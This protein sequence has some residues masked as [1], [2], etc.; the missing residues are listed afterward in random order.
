MVVT[1]GTISAV[2]VVLGSIW[3]YINVYTFSPVYR[4]AFFK[5]IGRATDPRVFDSETELPDSELPSI[6]VLLP[7]YDE[8]ETV[9][10]AIGALRDAEYPTEK[11]GVHVV[12]EAADR[13]T[14][15]ELA[16]LGAHYTFQTI[17]V[18]PSYPGDKNKPRA[19]NYGFEHTD[20]DI[21]GVVDAEDIVDPRL[22]RQVVNALVDND[23]D[24]VQGPLDLRNED[25]GLLNVLFRGEYGFWYGSIIPSY[26]RV[27]YPVPLGGTTNFI[28]RETLETVAERR[29][30]RFGPLWTPEQQAELTDAGLSGT[31]PW[32]PRNVTE[33]FELGLFLWELGRSMAMVTATTH[34]ES[35]VGLNA[36]VRQRTR[37]QRGKLYTLIRRL[38]EPPKGLKAKVHIY[39]QSAV[40]HLGPINIV[41]FALVAV[42]ATLIGLLASL[43]ATIILSIGL[44]LAVQM[45]AIQA[46]GYWNVTDK[47]GVKRVFRTGVNFFAVPLYWTLVWGSDVRAFLQLFFSTVGWEKTTHVGRHIETADPTTVETMLDASGLRL[48]LTEHVD[49]W[50]WAARNDD[51]EI[52][53]GTESFADE[54]TARRAA[55]RFGDTLAVAVGSGTRFEISGS[56]DGWTWVAVDGEETMAV[57]PDQFRD[58]AGAI[59]RVHLVR[60]LS[61]AATVGKHTTRSDTV[62]GGDPLDDPAPTNRP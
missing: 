62:S 34:G 20:G 24:F 6:D 16:R 1:V 18:P 19:L 29:I 28:T 36:W 9:G 26:F 3:I 11:L 31:T 40:P 27:R 10:H 52:A 58:A 8:A 43:P 61:G 35:P 39:T 30:E 50:T 60:E 33:D 7:A 55:E 25:D 14:R 53:R 38:S 57:S 41:A 17:V 45:M 21:V 54:D 32:D 5:F 59:D 12:V 37:W 56:D 42:Y 47:R 46:I 22:F 2:A 51:E 49:G 15:D 4:K 23:H 44:A 48:V 13:A